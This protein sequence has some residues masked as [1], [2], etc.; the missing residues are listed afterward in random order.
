VLIYKVLLAYMSIGKRELNKFYKRIGS[1]VKNLRLANDMSQLDLA[2]ESD[3]EKTTIS[4]LEN[5]G[6]NITAKTILRLSKALGV[7]PSML[8]EIQ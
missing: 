8:L 1:N 3:L 2:T 6:T 5:G 4:R 7:E